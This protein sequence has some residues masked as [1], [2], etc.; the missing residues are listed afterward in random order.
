MTR[1]LR[2]RRHRRIGIAL[3]CL[4]VGLMVLGALTPTAYAQAPQRV[5]WWNAAS[6]SGSPAGATAAPSPATPPGGLRVASGPTTPAGPLLPSQVPPNAQILAY[7]AVLY[8]LP[9]GSSAALKLTIAGSAQ[10]T[11][12]VVACPTT[13]TSWTA[14]DDQPASSE[15]AYDCATQHFAGTVSADAT[16]ITF[17]VKGQFETTP[18]LLSLA[19]VPDTTSTALPSGGAPFAVDFAAP[20]TGSFTP[21]PTSDGGSSNES[22]PPPFLTPATPTDVSAVP[23]GAPLALPEVSALPPVATAA[24]V[25]VTQGKPPAAAA[26]AR[27]PVTAIVADTLRARVASALGVATLLAAIVVWSLGYGLLGGRTI[28][29]SVPLRRG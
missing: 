16:T 20:D 28:P 13:T 11:P 25:P 17:Q 19:I 9:E 14:G 24:P 21:A 23:A 26:P 18:G 6:A 29:L 27:P 22:L 5:G 2:R 3:G 1:A 10:G 4:G 7:G 8:A 12:Q 15:P